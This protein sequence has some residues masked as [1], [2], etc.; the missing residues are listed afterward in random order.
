MLITP[1]PP[2]Q[3]VSLW[4]RLSLQKSPFYHYQVTPPLD[5]WRDCRSRVSSVRVCGV[6]EDVHAVCESEAPVLHATVESRPK[7]QTPLRTRYGTLSGSV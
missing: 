4:P 6:Q 5:T 7:A 3:R 2:G 1:P